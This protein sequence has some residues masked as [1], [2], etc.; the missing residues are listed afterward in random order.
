MAM[1]L[2]TFAST[3][4]AA[5]LLFNI[6]AIAQTSPTPH[7]DYEKISG[8]EI[9]VMPKDVATRQNLDETSIRKV[10]CVYRSNDKLAIAGLTKLI[11]ESKLQIGTDNGR[12]IVLRN[13]VRFSSPEGGTSLQFGEPQSG[14]VLSGSLKSKD[15][16]TSVAIDGEFI[17]NLHNW[18]IS[19]QLQVQ[20][21]PVG[22]H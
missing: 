18:I 2:Y 20:S 6:A 17:P 19:N 3:S 1:R 22:C 11:R 14:K 10:G 7:I 15:G 21:G 16:S 4:M 13:F 8:V 5:C 12:E 9:I